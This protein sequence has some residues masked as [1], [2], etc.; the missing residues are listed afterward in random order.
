MPEDY[1]VIQT[2]P[3]DSGSQGGE[4]RKRMDR[5]LL[6]LSAVMLIA[7]RKGTVCLEGNGLKP[8]GSLLREKRGV[9]V[10]F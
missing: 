3:W 5:M 7:N 8:G 4:R 1:R 6:F 2:R 10:C 9:G